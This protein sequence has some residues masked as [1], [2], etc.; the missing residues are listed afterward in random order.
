[1]KNLPMRKQGPRASL[2]PKRCKLCNWSYVLVGGGK[3]HPPCPDI[4][5]VNKQAERVKGWK[6]KK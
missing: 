2:K 6:K 4:S 5:Y 3:A 1:M